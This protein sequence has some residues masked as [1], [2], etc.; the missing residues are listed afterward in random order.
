MKSSCPFTH[1]RKAPVHLLPELRMCR[2]LL[3]AVIAF[4]AGSGSFTAQA[5]PGSAVLESSVLRLTVTASPFGFNVTEKSSGMS[6]VTQSKNTLTFG[7]AAYSVSSASNLVLT[8]TTLDADLYFAGITNR[9]HVDFSF[10]D[11]ALLQVT[12]TGT[13]GP[14]ATAMF[15]QFIDQGEEI[16]GAFECP[17]GGTVSARNSSGQFG[18]HLSVTNILQWCSAKAPFYLTTRHY[19]IY[20]ETDVLGTMTLGQGGFTSFSF[21]VPQLTYDIIYGATYADIMSGFNA[22]SG[23]ALM[24]PLWMFDSI[25]WKDD[26]HNTNAPTHPYANAQASV[27]DTAIQLTNYQIHASAE[28]IDRPYGTSCGQGEGGWGNFDFDASFP[29]PA[30]MV[31]DLHARGIN[32]MLWISDYCWCSLYTEGLAKGYL[33]AATDHTTADFRNPDAFNWFETKLNAF[34]NLGVKGYKIDRGDE[35]ETPDSLM[36]VNNTLFQQLAFTGLSQANPGDAYTFSRS[37]MDTAR[38]YTGLWNGDSACTFAG[39]QYSIISGLRAGIINFPMWGSDTGGYGLYPQPSTPSEELFAR[40]L[41]FS[42]YSP[43]MEVLIGS[44]RTPWY[45]YSANLVAIAHA[46]AAAHHDL[47]PYSRSYL[48]QAT[49]TGMPLIRP[50]IFSYPDDANLALTLTNCEFMFGGQILV[51]PVITGGSNHAQRVSAGWQMAGLQQPIQPLFG[52]RHHRRLRAV[53]H[54]PTL[55]QRRRDHPAGRYFPGEQ[56]VDSK[57]DT[58][59]AHRVFPRR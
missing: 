36:N 18:G 9:A 44:N 15:Q 37:A 38:K 19:G 11:P 2:H 25:W 57:L 24:P 51:A 45:D 52:A 46:Q 59:I 58:P 31:S 32:L 40:W 50:I 12:L 26:D 21:N 41:E 13:N 49:Q 54:H 35:G 53:G 8:A 10:T 39:L 23:G 4:V 16:L 56:L 28:W 7:G 47:I 3:T 17:T 48:Y 43:I 22:R 6:L 34:V 55:R 27:L 14:A 42:A 29:N 20:A 33:F 30:R 1:V 5:D